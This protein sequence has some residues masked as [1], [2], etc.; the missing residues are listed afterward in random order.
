MVTN[1]VLASLIAGYFYLSF[2]SLHF[3]CLFHSQ[4]FQTSSPTWLQMLQTLTQGCVECVIHKE[5][6]VQEE[7]HPYMYVAQT[8]RNRMSMTCDLYCSL[9]PQYEAEV[10]GVTF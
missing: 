4:S 1:V 9:L 10:T 8:S 3:T 6:D 2:F 5:R 7:K